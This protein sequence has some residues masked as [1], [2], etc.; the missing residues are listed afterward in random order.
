MIS[1]KRVAQGAIEGNFLSSFFAFLVLTWSILG[2]G[3]PALR[4]DWAIPPDPSRALNVAIAAFD[5]W[6]PVGFGQANPYPLNYAMAAL[7][8]PIIRVFGGFGEIVAILALTTVIAS[9]AASTINS[10]QNTPVRHFLITAL[11]LF[12]PWTYNQFVAGHIYM[13]F[14]CYALFVLAYD[15]IRASSA[16]MWRI[17]LC[18]LLTSQQMQFLL[19]ALCVCLYSAVSQRRAYPLTMLLIMSAPAILGILF[20]ID[21]LLQAPYHLAW[22]K[23]QSISFFDAVA[24]TGYFAGYAR[25]FDAVSRI[26]SMLILLLGILA[27]TKS[28]WN[29]SVPIAAIVFISAIVSAANGPLSTIFNLVMRWHVVGVYRELYDLVGIVVLAFAVIAGRV[30]ALHRAAIWAISCA[31]V[32]PLTVAW[33]AAPPFSFTVSASELPAPPLLKSTQGRYALFPPFQ[34][35]SLLGRG[36][37]VDPDSLGLSKTPLNEYLPTYPVDAALASAWLGYGKDEL[38]ALGVSN[39]IYRPKYTSDVSTLSG[40]WG[41]HLAKLPSLPKGREIQALQGAPLFSLGP[42]PR[43]SSLSNDLAGDNV[44]F[45]DLSC[46][47][48]RVGNNSCEDADVSFPRS[49]E[50]TDAHRAWI[51]AALLFVSHPELAQGLGGAATYSRERFDVTKVHAVLI[52]VDGRLV[53]NG[54]RD[55][56]LVRKTY[57]WVSLRNTDRWL[58]CEG[59][60]VIAA[61]S[62][63]LPRFPLNAKRVSFKQTSLNRVVPWLAYGEL[64][65]HG[66]TVSLR[67]NERYNVRWLGIVGGRIVP[68]VRLNRVMNS[69]IIAPDESPQLVILIEWVAALQWLAAMGAVIVYAAAWLGAARAL[70]LRRALGSKTGNHTSNDAQQ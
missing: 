35:L 10:S 24:M 42:P 3:V 11:L 40:Q 4:H 41:S 64:S 69:W 70:G 50:E 19:P 13:P 5:G 61:E 51:D 38:A 28:K 12:N 54:K 52:W 59:L 46:P 63:A 2:K 20:G 57:S 36:S 9:L 31:V 29:V 55:L 22:E 8:A 53:A 67:F 49:S 33:I 25:H 66:R 44:F 39:V 68:H 58:Q 18:L 16:P 23:T 21:T 17:L 32:A 48:S 1:A 34:P 37:G 56:E 15:V 43:T 27:I 65:S 6:N 30:M 14:A 7:L 45:G 60:C 47:A 26:S 62:N